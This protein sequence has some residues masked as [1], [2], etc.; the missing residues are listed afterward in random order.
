MKRAL[1]VNW[2]NY[3]NVASGGVYTWAKSLVESMSDWEFVLFNQLSNPNANA[4]YS[5]PSNVKQVIEL[6]IFGTNRFEEYYKS[7][8]PFL[9]RVRATTDSV[10][11]QEFLPLYKEFLE[12][13]FADDCDSRRLA[14]LIYSLHKFLTSHDTK[15]CFEH[16]LAWEI[17]LNRIQADPLYRE[18]RLR[19]ALGNFH[20]LQRSMQILSVDLPKVDIIHC[21]LAWLPAMVAIPAKMENNSPLVV[22]EHGV[23]FREL[24]L[25]YNAYL[26]N[27]PSK[28]F[29]TV[30][31][32]NIVRTIYTFADVIT[33]VCRANEAWEIGLG[34]DKSKIRVIYNGINIK[35]FRPMRLSEVERRPTVVSVARVSVFKDII[36]LIQAI[37]YVRG[38][39]RDI[40][41]LL[42]GSST[43]PEYSSRCM[44]LVQKLRL[45]AN[46]KFMGGTNEPEKA[47]N[48]ADV[49]AFSSITEGFPFG[50]IEA[51]ACGKAVVATDVGGVREALE[52]CG[53]LVR[54]R[55]PRELA[56]GIIKLLKDE[57]L[58]KGFEAA[59]LTRI[60]EEFTLE[61]EVQQYRELYQQLAPE[62][63]DRLRQPAQMVAV[64]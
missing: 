52:G 30:F 33:P 25:Y 43:E 61:K 47:Y 6:P 11:K 53:L 26:Y 28:I 40:R 8:R 56:N 15:K 37:N 46:F 3:P 10:I 49:V 42:F 45:E 1:L 27:E 57:P 29:W 16:Y 31:T 2:D 48:L 54:S 21:S 18:M 41:C 58:R 32:R 39:V 9:Q 20:A 35:K 4:K 51:M 13:V 14:D 7:D 44:D 63:A 55:S 36:N 62:K 38:T 22:T 23:A 64:R 5:V 60:K 24:V 50:V 17:F 12:R 34:V 19:E 59:A